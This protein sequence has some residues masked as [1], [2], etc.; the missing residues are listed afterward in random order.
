MSAAQESLGKPS[1]VSLVTAVLVLT[2]AWAQDFPTGASLTL[3]ADGIP[4]NLSAA[5][6]AGEALPD[7]MEISVCVYLKFL[8]GRDN[9][10]TLVSYATH[11]NTNELYIGFAYPSRLF[12]VWWGYSLIV[13]ANVTSDILRWWRLCYVHNFT[14]HSYTVYW[15]DRVFTGSF[16]GPEALSGGGILVLGQDQDTLGGGFV[17]S[18]SLNAVLKDFRFYTRAVTSQEAVDYTSCRPSSQ[19]LKPHMDFT[20]LLSDWRLQGSVEVGVV[21]MSEVCQEESVFHLVFPEKRTFPEAA[22]LCEGVGGN[23]AA[24]T[25]PKENQLILSSVSPYLQQCLDA[26]GEVVFLGFKSDPATRTL[27]HYNTGAV[28][29]FTNLTSSNNTG[30]LCLG[31]QMTVNF[32]G[33]WL[34]ILCKHRICTLCAFHALSRLKVCPRCVCLNI[35]QS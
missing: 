1:A 5:F 8:R 28:A 4:T 27:T 23:V 25:T 32:Q 12:E 29:Q 15:N 30:K 10:D 35:N 13:R 33:S 16:Q 7:T 31:F 9:Y 20:H 26:S 14:T 17:F 21:E 24:P 11:N 22:A 19:D 34:P 6:W 18:Q 3:Q 2:T